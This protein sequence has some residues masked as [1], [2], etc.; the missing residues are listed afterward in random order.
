MYIILFSD[1]FFKQG[2][3]NFA[4]ADYHQ[5]LEL[6]PYDMTVKKRCSI[7]H[8]EFGV[9]E[10]QQKNLADA[11]AQFTLAIQNNP[12]TGQYYISRARARHLLEVCL[13]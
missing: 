13:Y 1:C 4:L 12:T 9:A 6:D 8:N 11:V 7:I 10:Y 5:A 2:E 3:L